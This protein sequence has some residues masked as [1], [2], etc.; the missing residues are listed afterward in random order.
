MDPIFGALSLAINALKGATEV[1]D[2]ARIEDA[3]SKVRSALIEAQ[4]AVL[5]LQSSE[6]SNLK[7]IS[8]LEKKV[9]ELEKQVEVAEDWQKLA[10][11]YTLRETAPGNSVW[12]RE[13]DVKEGLA[14]GYKEGP[15]LACSNCFDQRKRSILRAKTMDSLMV[16]CPECKQSA[17]IR[18]EPRYEQ[19]NFDSGP[20][21]LEF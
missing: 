12:V 13:Y 11:C 8:A 5:S 2:K 10:D 15:H 14:R 4:Q 3:V 18:A 16:T 7:T 1:W 20:R 17:Q 19:P 6:N 21:N 9:R